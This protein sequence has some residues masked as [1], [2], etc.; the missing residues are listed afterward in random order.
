VQPLTDWPAE[1]RRGI[2]GVFTD[3]DDTLTHAGRIA[4]EALQALTDLRAAGLTV[5]AITGRPIGWCAPWL[6][7]SA[8][9]AWPVDAVV[10]ENGGVAYVLGSQCPP[11]LREALS[12]IYQ[13]DPEARAANRLRMDA[14]ARDVCA[15]VPGLEQSRDSAGRESDL[16][17]DYAEFAQHPPD[18]VRRV[19]ALLQGHGMQ[20]AVSSIHIHG[21]F[22]DF[23]KWTG[24]RW[25][26]R[27]LWGRE[28]AQ[29]LDHWVF[30]GDSG[31][32]EA[33][34]E[35]FSHSVGVANIARCAAQLEH[36]PRYVAPSEYGAGF[37][38]VARAILEAKHHD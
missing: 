15:A 11:V 22:G 5:I 12:K 1:S 24:A 8:G 33:L 30:V 32:D 37:A 2:R 26:V 31:N 36:L 6:D 3:I 27:E 13:E 16:A 23:N 35:R 10:A 17:F 19:V 34:F 28:L 7:G 14:I 9:P 4:P 29:E 25:I 20:T 21:C 18:T 38:D